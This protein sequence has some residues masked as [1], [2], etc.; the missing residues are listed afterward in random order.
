MCGYCWVLI[1]DIL[2]SNLLFYTP[3]M[4]PD[5]RVGLFNQQTL[6]VCKFACMCDKERV[7]DKHT[8][9]KHTLEKTGKDHRST[10]LKN[11]INFVSLISIA[12]EGT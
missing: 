4:H 1:I 11:S 3:T 7:T 8:H 6:S 2:Q 5:N 9:T 10:F 12:G